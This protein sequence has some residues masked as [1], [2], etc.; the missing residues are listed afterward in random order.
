MIGV[1]NENGGAV[2]EILA[3]G[4]RLYIYDELHFSFA[5]NRDAYYYL[6]TFDSSGRTASPFQARGSDTHDMTGEP[7]HVIKLDAHL[8]HFDGSP[9]I[10]SMYILASET[11]LGETEPILWEIEKIDEGIKSGT[12]DTPL[13]IEGESDYRI[14]A[15]MEI[16]NGRVRSIE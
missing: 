4:S 3:E 16:E 1:R 9:T 8:F 15:R 14:V 2:H 11:E 10:H 5:S 7:E 12:Q 13:S 6:F